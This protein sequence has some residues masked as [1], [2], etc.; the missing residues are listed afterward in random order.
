MGDLLIYYRK[1]IQ[2]H[3]MQSLKCDDILEGYLTTRK[4]LLLLSVILL[5]KKNLVAEQLTE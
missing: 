1:L 2:G 4:I 5:S 3:A